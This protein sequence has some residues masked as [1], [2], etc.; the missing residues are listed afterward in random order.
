MATDFRKYFHWDKTSLRQECIRLATELEGEQKAVAKLKARV[1]MSRPFTSSD[2]EKIKFPTEAQGV[3]S[4]VEIQSWLDAKLTELQMQE[5]Q[6]SN[7]DK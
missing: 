3:W 4:A 2:L 5:N 1:K 7:D 6:E